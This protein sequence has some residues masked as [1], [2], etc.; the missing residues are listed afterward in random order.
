VVSFTSPPLYPRERA[1]GTH[2]IEGWVGPRA[3]LD[4]VVKRIFLTL[5]VLELRPLGRATHSQ[6]LYRLL[7]NTELK[8]SSM[9]LFG[10]TETLEVLI[11]RLK[12]DI[13]ILRKY[14]LNCSL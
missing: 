14:M 12:T 1:P 4:D 6:S 10:L 9:S 11:F 5:T 8:A 2:W 7:H 3:G 13:V